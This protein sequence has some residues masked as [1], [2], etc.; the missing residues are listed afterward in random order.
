MVDRNNKRLK[1][2]QINYISREVTMNILHYF[3]N[4]LI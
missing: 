3:I 4:N 2:T 1:P